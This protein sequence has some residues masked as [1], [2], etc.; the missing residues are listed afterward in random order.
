MQ[1]D[2]PTAPGLGALGYKQDW[3]VDDAVEINGVAVVRHAVVSARAVVQ[4]KSLLR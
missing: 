3:S 4:P 1:P 2:R